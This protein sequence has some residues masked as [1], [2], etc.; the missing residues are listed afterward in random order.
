MTN[1]IRW[2]DGEWTLPAA[3]ALNSGVPPAEVR[4]QLSAAR[5][6]KMIPGAVETVAENTGDGVI[7]PLFFLMLF[8]NRDQARP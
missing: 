3:L 7:A 8:L 1:T 4:K 6:A 5:A 2:P